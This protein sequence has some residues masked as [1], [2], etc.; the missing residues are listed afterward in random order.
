MSW[1]SSFLH[2]GRGYQKGQ[3]QL[4]KYYQQANSFQQPFLNN[5]SSAY[6]GLNTAMQNLLDPEA[7]QSKWAESYEESPAA[8]QARVLATQSGL[9]AASSMGL[10][11]SSPALSALQEGAT[12]ISLKDRANY[13][14]DLMQKYMAGIGVGQNIYGTGANAAGQMGQ[15]AMN[16]GQNSAQ[17]AFGQQNA[18]GDLFSKI[19]GGT[20]GLVGGPIGN[21]LSPGFAQKM[22][23]SEPGSYQPWSF[24]GGR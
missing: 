19:L 17:M 7:L 15:N 3:Q 13:M 14:N 8:Q 16:M 2:P 5:A 10:M 12:N 4:D 1:L 18:G 23:W 9:D 20:L 22:G 21:A 11:G 6:G 24:T